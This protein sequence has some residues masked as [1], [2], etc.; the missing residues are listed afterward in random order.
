[1]IGTI[2]PNGVDTQRVDGSAGER[3]SPESEK[4]FEALERE[5]RQGAGTHVD[6]SEAQSSQARKVGRRRQTVEVKEGKDCWRRHLKRDGRERGGRTGRRAVQGRK[7][8]FRDGKLT[9][10]GLRNPSPPDGRRKG[11]ITY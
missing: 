10:Q 8:F 1:M 2:D 6:H 4:K 9:W 7:H 5:R 11:L 3:E